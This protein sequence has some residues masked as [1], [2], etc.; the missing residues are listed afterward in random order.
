MKSEETYLN[1]EDRGVSTSEW[2]NYNSCVIEN[3]ICVNRGQQMLAEDACRDGHAAR[4]GNTQ[5]GILATNELPNTR[6]RECRNH[7]P[8]GVGTLPL[9]VT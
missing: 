5:P 3:G 7:L 6:N 9:L 8:L 1:P 2:P 4:G